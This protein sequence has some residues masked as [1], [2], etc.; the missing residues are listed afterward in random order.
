MLEGIIDMDREA[1]LA[2]R[3]T[4]NFREDNPSWG[5]SSSPHCWA[6]GIEVNAKGRLVQLRR[7]NGSITG[8]MSGV[9]R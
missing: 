8:E 6:P 2:L 7:T 3:V 1:L 9:R 5:S 4:T